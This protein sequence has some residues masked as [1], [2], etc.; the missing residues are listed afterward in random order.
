MSNVNNITD[1]FLQN[2]FA[3]FEVP[4]STA[5]RIQMA[6]KIKVYNFLHFNP[7]TVN[8]FYL[9][10]IILVLLTATVCFNLIHGETKQTQLIPNNNKSNNESIIID[11]QKKE[12]NEKFSNNSKIEENQ[13]TESTETLENIIIENKSSDINFI[14]SDGDKSNPFKKNQE[15]QANDQKNQ[16]SEPEI[17]LITTKSIE[18]PETS[19]ENNQPEEVIEVK[20]ENIV[21]DTVYNTQKV[22]VQD[23]VK[24]VINQTIKQK[25]G[26]RNR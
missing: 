18:E 10:A 2:S 14:Y 23:T 6:R 24:Q 1:N 15:I 21:Y 7:W 20:Q 13:N 4:V 16:S 3:E 5:A 12:E 9:S 22:V 19:S 26:K 25:R 8:V 11:N 17:E